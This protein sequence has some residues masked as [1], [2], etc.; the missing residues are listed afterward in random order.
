MVPIW[1]RQQ[2]VGSS[3]LL[4]GFR[5]PWPAAVWKQMALVLTS[6]PA[7]PSQPNAASRSLRR[8]P[9]FI[10]SRRHFIILHHPEKKGEYSTIRYFGR[11]RPHSH[12]VS[13]HS[14]VKPVTVISSSTGL[15]SKLNMITGMCVEG[16][17]EYRYGP[18]LP[19]PQASTG[20][21]GL[22]SHT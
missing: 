11:E 21:L 19:R 5:C 10:P 15:I 16:N 14:T 7:A 20:D 13:L 18:V 8:S 3:A 9:H 4:R 17:K 2:P 6:R 22:I 1:V 12:R